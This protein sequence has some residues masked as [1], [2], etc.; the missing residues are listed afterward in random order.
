MLQDS[1]IARFQNTLEMFVTNSMVTSK[2][3]IQVQELYKGD[4]QQSFANEQYANLIKMLEIGTSENQ[5]QA[6]AAMKVRDKAAWVLDSRATTHISFVPISRMGNQNDSQP[7]HP[8]GITLLN[9]SF[10]PLLLPD[11][12]CSVTTSPFV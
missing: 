5:I 10:V 7:S 12:P 2:D 6:N 4:F 11:Q 8:S 9:G 1:S 3:T